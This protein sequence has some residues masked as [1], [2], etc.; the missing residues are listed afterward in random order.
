MKDSF[1]VFFLLF[2]S[3]FVAVV[4]LISFIP[5]TTSDARELALADSTEWLG[6]IT[7]NGKYSGIDPGFYGQNPPPTQYYRTDIEIGLRSDGIVVWRK[8]KK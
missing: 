5:H 4:L 2:F 6:W 8:I 1:N 3:C 7:F